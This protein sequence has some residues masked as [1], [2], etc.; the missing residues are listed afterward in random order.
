L[1]DVKNPPSHTPTI[2][3]IQYSISSGSFLVEQQTEDLI[4][5][6][7]EP[8]EIEEAQVEIRPLDFR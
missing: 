6:N 5:V 7:T 4:I 2:G 8:G 3:S 1:T